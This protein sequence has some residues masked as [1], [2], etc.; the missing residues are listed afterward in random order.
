MVFTECLQGDEPNED[1]VAVDAIMET[2]LFD[3]RK[4]REH[5]Q[6]IVDLLLQLP[7]EFR[8]SGGGGWSFLQAC[9]DRQGHQWGEH[10]DMARLFALGMAA[11][12]V[13][14]QMPRSMWDKLP[15]GMP[16]YIILD[17]EGKVEIPGV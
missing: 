9:M 4:V 1:A 5:A 14:C 15:G 13:Y 3:N 10:Q 16:Y 8:M 7:N 12:F 2:V 11:G 17:K 6:D